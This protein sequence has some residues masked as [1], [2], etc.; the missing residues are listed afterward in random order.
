MINNMDERILAELEIKKLNEMKTEN[1][2]SEIQLN[3]LNEWII[4]IEMQIADFDSS[5]KQEEPVEEDQP[6]P[7]E[8]DNEDAPFHDIDKVGFI[9]H[10]EGVQPEVTKYLQNTFDDWMSGVRP[11]RPFQYFIGGSKHGNNK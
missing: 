6:E 8:V 7:K 11:L 10:K 9:Q 2:L 4:S 5:H 1:K 3:K